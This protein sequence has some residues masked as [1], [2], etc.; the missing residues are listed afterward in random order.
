MPASSAEICVNKHRK[1]ATVSHKVIVR[2]DFLLR[3]K[4]ISLTFYCQP[5][6]SPAVP[7]NGKLLFQ[8]AAGRGRRAHFQE[9]TAFFH[10]EFH[11]LLFSCLKKKFFHGLFRLHGDARFHSILIFHD[12]SCVHGI[13]HSSQPSPY[14]PDAVGKR[15]V[16]L[17][18]PGIIS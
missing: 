17:S 5:G 16:I 8:N 11:F 6:K 12:N 7:D 13:A 2:Q 4:E 14:F 3:E 10:K 9:N 18:L 1:P 15:S